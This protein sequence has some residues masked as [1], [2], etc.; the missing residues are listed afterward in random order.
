MGTLTIYLILLKRFNII[1]ESIIL[2]YGR[3]S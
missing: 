3:L 2:E 1:K